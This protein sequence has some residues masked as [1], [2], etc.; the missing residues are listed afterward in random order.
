MMQDTVYVNGQIGSILVENLCD[1]CLSS[2]VFFL[3]LF[4]F[5]FFLRMFMDGVS[6]VA[7]PFFLISSVSFTSSGVSSFLSLQA[8]H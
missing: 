2:I 5:F 3:G 7:L 1:F 8:G 4:S 6:W